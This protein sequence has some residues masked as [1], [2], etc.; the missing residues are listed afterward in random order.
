MNQVSRAKTRKYIFDVQL[1]DGSMLHS[2]QVFAA[3]RAS[4]MTDV[5][6]RYPGCQVIDT[7]AAFGAQR[8]LPQFLLKTGNKD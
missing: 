1:R 4:A 7:S 5:R 3:T 8:E 6:R 2:F